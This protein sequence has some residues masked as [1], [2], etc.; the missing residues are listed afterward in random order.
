MLTKDIGHHRRSGVDSM[1][2][3][4]QDL[5][6]ETPR[7]N[8]YHVPRGRSKK[9][10]IAL[11]IVTIIVLSALFYLVFSY[12]FEHSPMTMTQFID[13]ARDTNGDGYPDDYFPYKEGEN[14]T[15]RD[16]I[17]GFDYDFLFEYGR[18]GLKFSYNGKKRK[19]FY[20]WRDGISAYLY[21]NVSLCSYGL[22]DWITLEGTI[23]KSEYYG[24]TFEH[25]AWSVA[26]ET[27]PFNLPSVDLNLTQVSPEVWSIEVS[28]C[29]NS[30]KLMHFEV[31]LRRYG[32]GWDW[33]KGLEHGKKSTSMEFWDIDR[34]EYLST[35]DKIYVEP[36][37]DGEYEIAVFFHNEELE[38]V[39][40]EYYTP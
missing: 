28:D 15:V 7:S 4:G 32:Y 35:G 12:P 6:D 31:V 39:S 8:V 33:L 22:G 27:G 21:D 34:D 14:V 2:P 18:W 38:T 24:M 1:N 19:E 10:T 36:W 9:V 30:C 40:W 3:G 11:A 26:E 16:R 13:S 5:N 23:E 20:A 17:A 25:V 29:N 37:Q